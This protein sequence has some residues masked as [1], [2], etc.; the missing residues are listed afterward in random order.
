MGR[1]RAFDRETVLLAAANAFRKR[2]YRDISIAELEKATGLVSGSIYNAFKDKA[3]LF[4]AAL[5]YYVHG[6]VA[7][8]L[9]RF[10]GED[11]NLEDLEGLYLSLLAHPLADGFGCLVT[12]SIVEFGREDS[13]ASDGVT[14]SLL[15]AREAIG[16]VLGRELGSDVKATHTMQLL[17]LY[18]G[19]L[20]LSR[21]QLATGEL[22]DATRAVFGQLKDMRASRRGAAFQSKDKGD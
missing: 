11:A 20:T 12:N 9:R 21:S 19:L 17:I 4:R 18:H 13:P 2:S 14:A 3:G 15:A 10:A 22:A 7:D 5:D 1:R 6:F 16:G 8:R